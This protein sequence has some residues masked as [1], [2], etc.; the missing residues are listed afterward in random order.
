MV[1]RGW[2]SA[3][4]V[5]VAPRAVLTPGFPIRPPLKLLFWAPPKLP[6]LRLM[7]P[8]TASSSASFSSTGLARPS[9]HL[10]HTQRPDT[11]A[12]ADRPSELSRYIIVD[13]P[14]IGFHPSS[15]AYSPQRQ[16]DYRWRI[17]R[18]TVV[19]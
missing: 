4:G 2:I 17:L 1:A 7:P 6:K 9:H 12:V 13:A 10:P 11:L 19:L 14:L 16:V 3:T 5:W 15:L 18:S 8:A